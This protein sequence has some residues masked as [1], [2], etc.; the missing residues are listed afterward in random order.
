MLNCYLIFLPNAPETHLHMAKFFNG[1]KKHDA[2]LIE[3]SEELRHAFQLCKQQLAN[4]LLLVYLSILLEFEMFTD[5][6]P[7]SE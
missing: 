1:N 5:H 7:L 6:K 2:S 4:A 3:W